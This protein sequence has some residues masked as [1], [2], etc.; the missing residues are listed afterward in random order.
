[1]TKIP[2]S[3]PPQPVRRLGV[4]L[5]DTIRIP[6]CSEVF[7]MAAVTTVDEVPVMT[8]DEVPV[9]DATSQML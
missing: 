8:V 6:P 1:V 9:T 3:K 7:V 4:Q 2:L 5:V